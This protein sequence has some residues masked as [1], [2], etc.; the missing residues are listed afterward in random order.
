MA[1]RKNEEAGQIAFLRDICA[2]L[3]PKQGDDTE[4]RVEAQKRVCCFR[5]INHSRLFDAVAEELQDGGYLCD[6]PA[7]ASCRA[8]L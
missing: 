6:D 5:R 2:E 4:A 8:G 1:K 7:C 3:G